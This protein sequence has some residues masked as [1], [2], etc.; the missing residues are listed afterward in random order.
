[1]LKDEDGKFFVVDLKWSHGTH[2]I[3]AAD[4][5]RSVQLAAYAWAL[6]PAGFDVKSAYY[7]FPRKLFYPSEAQDHR[8]T[9]ENVLAD[10]RRTL[11]EMR[12]GILHKGYE[13]GETKLGLEP[14]C[15]FCPV[16]ALC[17][18]ERKEKGA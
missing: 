2:F 4:N 14:G 12:G 17:G 15:K 9:W 18:K 1:M 5:G 11:G 10:Y 8:E 16:K 7:M 6:E 3:D 13:A